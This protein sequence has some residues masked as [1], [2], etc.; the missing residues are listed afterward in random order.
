[1]GG[2]YEKGRVR[3]GFVLAYESKSKQVQ[4]LSAKDGAVLMSETGKEPDFASD[5]LFPGGVNIESGPEAFSRVT[6]SG[7]TI[8]KADGSEAGT[9][10]GHFSEKRRWAASIPLDSSA[11][12]EAYTSL[13]KTSS[14][15]TPVI[16]PTA[17]PMSRST[18]VRARPRSRAGSSRF[19][20]LRRVRIVSSG[21][22]A[23]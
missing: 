1:M 13:A 2:H 7:A 21:P 6:S 18:Q 22:S 9:V 11:L 12:K 4:V 15:T 5:S 8:Y 14:S 20:S 23:V 3:N 16:G 19:Q 10:T 17:Q